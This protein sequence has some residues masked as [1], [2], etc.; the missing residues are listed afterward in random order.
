MSS[1]LNYAKILIQKMS[2]DR[3][4]LNKEYRKCLGYLSI[5][6]REAFN[7]WLKSQPYYSKVESGKY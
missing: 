1:F 5:Q 3:H 4:L 7:T 2:F 6:E